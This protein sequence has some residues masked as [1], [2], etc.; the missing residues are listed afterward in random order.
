MLCPKGLGHGAN[1]A[2]HNHKCPP[3]PPRLE[4]ALDPL[5]ACS[6]VDAILVSAYCRS[7]FASW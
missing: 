7:H 3:Q 2:Y 5:I 6:I 4:R 1:P